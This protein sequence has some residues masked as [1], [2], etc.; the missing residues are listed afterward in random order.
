MTTRR[1][2]LASRARM[3]WRLGRARLP[4]R[5][6]VRLLPAGVRYDVDAV[7]PAIDAPQGDTRLLIGSRNFAGQGFAW[8]RAA[9]RLPG[10]A[11]MAMQVGGG[12]AFA[13]RAD[14]TVD[15]RVWT[16]SFPWS[17][18]QRA[19]VCDGFTHVLMEAV[20][21]I[22]GAAS[23]KSV[24]RELRWQRDAGIQV[25]MVCHGTDIRLP[26]RHAQLDEW[27]PFRDAPVE[28]L[29]AAEA[30]ARYKQ[31]VLDRAGAPVFVST[32]D[33]LLDRPEATWLPVV[34]DPRRWATEQAVFER[35]SLVVLHAPTNPRLKGTPLIEPVLEA[36]SEEGWMDYRRVQNVPSDRMPGIYSEADVVLEQFALGMY[37]V[38]AVEAMAAG[39][40]VIGHVH[41]QVR[42]HV[43]AV[44]GMDVPV[45]EA[46]PATLD[47]VLR[48]VHAR[49]EHYRAFAHAGTAFAAAV[50]DGRRSAQTLAPFLGV[51]S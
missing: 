47:T 6:G 28:W 32:P 42:D 9:E 7:P 1:Q 13:F 46:T 39:R 8:A 45:I 43:R 5:I 23:D 40:L 15:D 29:A 2:Q 36:L 21:S 12:D 31:S 51:A 38:T 3:A 37:S 30:R 41:E 16:N 34:V 44:T 19:A 48:D 10:V 33:L 20:V 25:A 11:A 35:E 49:R 27:S 24:A 26:S 22:F 4:E 18:R 14:Y 17:V 50:H